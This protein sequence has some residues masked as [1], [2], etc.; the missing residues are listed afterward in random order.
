MKRIFT[1]LLLV[2]SSSLYFYAQNYKISDVD[3]TVHSSNFGLGVTSS[4]AIK[5]NFPLNYSTL[6]SDEEL[7][8]YLENYKQ[9][10]ISSRFFDKVDINYKIEEAPQSNANEIKNI[11]VIIELTD[12]KHI[13]AVPYPKF[14]GDKNKN[15]IITKLKAKDT[16]FLGTMNP[17]AM[18]I[19]IE[20]KM[21]ENTD[22]W[23][24]SPGLN[25]S[26]DYPFNL[27][28][29]DVTWVN[30]YKL[31]YTFGQESPEWTAKSG[32]KFELPF[33]KFSL[34]FDAFQ[35]FFKDYDYK[36]YGDDLFFKE[37]FQ[38]SSPI[39]LFQLSNYT[40]ITYR[41][42]FNFNWYWDSDQIDKRNDDLSSPQYTLGHSISN[43]KINWTNNYRKGYSISL[44]NSFMYNIQRQDLS[45]VISF[46]GKYFTYFTF[47]QRNYFDI[48]GICSNLFAF[49]YFDLP[50]NTYKYGS[51]IGSRLRGIA[52]ESYFGN[53]KP[54]YTS[55]T[56][57]VLNLDFPLD[58]IRTA[59]SPDIINMNIQFSPFFDFALYRD[60]NK[61]SQIAAS[62][63]SGFEVLVYPKKWASFIIRGSL[64]FDLKSVFASDSLIKGLW[65]NKEITF[66]LGLLF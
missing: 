18:D 19:N 20:A 15:I 45:P 7:S 39:K 21:D 24:F 5:K 27:A 44:S 32:F 62:Y 12:S 38:V 9:N 40:N 35:Y 50:N 46:E 66:G 57:L 31:S 36:I 37:E 41:P 13:L 56:A 23:Q 42:Y 6:F 61:E 47:A 51:Q 3:I 55:S 28:L 25:L 1:V 16:N 48:L 54:S 65:H 49:T 2:L 43:S 59:F 30:D 22:K 4:Y 64:G 60:R 53:D 33:E 29:F 11:L 58:I 63:S 14:T 26:Y 8:L 10:L 34:E 52:D 17:L